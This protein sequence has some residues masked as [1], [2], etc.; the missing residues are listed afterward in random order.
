MM[1]VKIPLRLDIAGS[2]TD[3]PSYIGDGGHITLPLDYYVTIEEDLEDDESRLVMEYT[4]PSPFVEEINKLVVEHF[5]TRLHV[6][7]QGVEMIPLTAKSDIKYGGGLGGS[8]ST[9]VGI[10]RYYNQKYNWGFNAREEAGIAINVTQAQRGFCGRQDEYNAAL[11]CPLYLRYHKGQT[12]VKT[13][14]LSDDFKR[15]INSW[16]LYNMPREIDGQT[17]MEHEVNLKADVGPINRFTKGMYEAIANDDYETFRRTYGFHW[18]YVEKL[19]PLKVQSGLKDL[20]KLIP[21]VLIRHVG[22]GGGGY[23]L[24]HGDVVEH[25]CGTYRDREGIIPV[26]LKE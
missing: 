23:A 17:I 5:N 9:M 2:F 6:G 16:S 18:Q 14:F 7:R 22:A 8:S 3:L 13:L 25:D 11:G 26:K 20:R 19:N 12:T 1:K 4:S 24:I 21:G 10:I 15:K